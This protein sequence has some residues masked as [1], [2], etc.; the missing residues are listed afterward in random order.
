IGAAEFLVQWSDDPAIQSYALTAIGKAQQVKGDRVV[1][2]RT[3]DVARMTARRSQSCDAAAHADYFAGM[4]ATDAATKESLLQLVN[5]SSDSLDDAHV[6][7]VAVNALTRMR[8][9][10]YDL[11]GC[12]A[13]CDELD[14]MSQRFGSREGE[15]Q[16]SYLRARA[17]G[18]VMDN[19]RALRMIQQTAA[20]ANELLIPRFVPM[21]WIVQGMVCEATGKPLEGI[22]NHERAIAEAQPEDEDLLALAH[23]YAADYLHHLGRFPAANAHLD[24]AFEYAHKNPSFLANVLMVAV[25][26][27]RDEG[28]FDEAIAIARDALGKE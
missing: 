5:A 12:Y 9:E 13:Y 15:L 14:R 21:T 23:G 10:P 20:L 7:F 16:A 2:N 18:T 11:S 27:R 26:T 6:A 22:R 25:G 28:R 17:A 3:L 8:C 4:N 24:R 1:A 19:A